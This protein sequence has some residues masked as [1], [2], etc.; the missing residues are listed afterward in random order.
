MCLVTQHCDPPY[1]AKGYGYTYRFSVFRYHKVLC[2]TPSPQNSPY[3]TDMSL[4]IA[5]SRGAHKGGYR[6]SRLRSAG[7]RAVGGPR[8]RA[9]P[10]S[11]FSVRVAPTVSYLW[12][13]ATEG[14]LSGLDTTTFFLVY[15]LVSQFNL[16]RSRSGNDRELTTSPAGHH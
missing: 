7:H 13:I 3:H 9:R 6:R 14:F 11:T 12:S 16:S 5:A 4:L 2:Y 1:C 8:S 15:F 10:G